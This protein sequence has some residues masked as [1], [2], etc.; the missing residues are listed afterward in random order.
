MAVVF[1]E[2][3]TKDDLPAERPVNKSA[4]HPIRQLVD[5]LCNYPRDHSHALSIAERLINN[6]SFEAA[7]RLLSKLI[8]I[9]NNFEVLHLLSKTLYQTNQWGEC[10]RVTRQALMLAEGY[11]NH[12]FELLKWL[13]NCLIHLKDF[14]GAQD[15][16]EKAFLLFPG[17]APL[18][19]NF[20]TLWIQK[21]EWNL[22]NEC[23][24][25]A[26]FLNGE[27]DPAWVGLAICHHIK[28]DFDLALTNLKRALDSNPCNETALTL[29]FGWCRSREDLK[30]A[31]NLY[32]KFV[33]E[34]AFSINLSKDFIRTAQALGEN[35]LCQL[36]KFHLKIR[37]GKNV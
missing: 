27:Y 30:T 25:T 11:R 23:F 10:I 9:E 6:R 7:E 17:S 18:L 2:N 14:D 20:G 33:D 4:V 13:G 8:T 36:E 3:V 16:Y 29:F 35:R 22:A 19:V 15:A 5:D 26:V 32:M 28:G 24:R 37:G 1:Q 34:G 12:R 31:M 21:S